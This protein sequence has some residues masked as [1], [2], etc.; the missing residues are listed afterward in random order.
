MQALFCKPCGSLRSGRTGRARSA[1]RF[2][3]SAFGSDQSHSGHL[4]TP[5]LARTLWEPA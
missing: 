1:G 3:A 2:P 5:R 4:Q